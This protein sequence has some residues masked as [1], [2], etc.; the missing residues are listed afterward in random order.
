MIRATL[1]RRQVPTRWCGALLIVTLVDP[2]ASAAPAECV[3]LLHG[4]ARGSHSMSKL[5]EALREGGYV[6]ANI[7]YPSRQHPVEELAPEAVGRGLDAC[8]DTQAATIHFVTHSMGAIL[9]RYYLSQ[10]AIPELGRVVMLGPP[11][12]G[13]EVVDRFSK[14]PGFG[15]INGP[16]GS[17]L[18]TGPESL[19][20]TLGPVSYPVGVIAGTKTINPI[21][22]TALPNP[23]DGKVS[24]ARTRVEGMAD[25]IAVA[26]SHPLLVRDAEAIRQ[27]LA[28]LE[29]GKFAHAASPPAPPSDGSST[30]AR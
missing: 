17:Q 23:D 19:P 9:V 21:L 11:N 28:F 25:F 29:D 30:T 12:Q 7:D 27:T 16:A 14:V 4:L 15:A 5:E 24:V 2:W 3:I 20:S 18:G 26:A 8:R 1:G 6:I 13:S 22:S 10:N